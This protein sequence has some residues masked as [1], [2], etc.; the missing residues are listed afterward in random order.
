KKVITYTKVQQFLKEHFSP[1][2]SPFP[3]LFPFFNPA[4][5]NGT[6]APFNLAQ[7]LGNQLDQRREEEPNTESKEESRQEDH[8]KIPSLANLELPKVEVSSISPSGSSEASVSTEQN[9]EHTDASS[10]GRSVE[11]ES[12]DDRKAA[13]QQPSEAPTITAVER[14][15]SFTSLSHL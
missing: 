2:P 5:Q 3:P 9:H 12:A 10:M 14:P 13:Q 15:V 11:S 6:P 8:L 1:F 4:A 7:L